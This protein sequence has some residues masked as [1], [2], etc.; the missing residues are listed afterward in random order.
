MGPRI[1]GP[2]LFIALRFYKGQIFTRIKDNRPVARL[3]G[4]EPSLVLSSFKLGPRLGGPV[5]QI[6]F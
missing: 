5:L 2:I 3:E 4:K 1:M 6:P